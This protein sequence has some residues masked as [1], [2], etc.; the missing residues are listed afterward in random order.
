VVVF[1]GEVH[2]GLKM[3]QE[4]NPYAERLNEDL[5]GWVTVS[6]PPVAIE[7]PA[8]PR[9]GAATCLS[10]DGRLLAVGGLLEA[11]SSRSVDVYDHA[12]NVWKPIGSLSHERAHAAALAL[13]DGSVLVLGGHAHDRGEDKLVAVVERL[14]F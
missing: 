6:D 11:T 8:P 13:P 10:S 12:T 7:M 2:R 5:T 14:R 4:P 1:G 3:F 9:A